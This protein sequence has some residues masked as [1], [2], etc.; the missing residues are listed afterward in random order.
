MS[1]IEEVLKRLHVGVHSSDGI[2]RIH[3]ISFVDFIIHNPN[4]SKRSLTHQLISVLGVRERTVLEYIN[5]A[6]A[7][8][9]LV[10]DGGEIRYN[11]TY[12]TKKKGQSELSMIPEKTDEEILRSRR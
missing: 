4:N 12:K 8:N 3:W 9:V 11:K 1:E 2:N 10:L 6:I 7:W 5:C